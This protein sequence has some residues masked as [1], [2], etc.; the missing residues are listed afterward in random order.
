MVLQK[1]SVECFDDHLAKLKNAL[2]MMVDDEPI[3]TDVIQIHLETAGYRNFLITDRSGE[4][5]ELLRNQKPDVLLLDLKMP[6]VTGFDILSEMRR[7]QL[8]NN[9]PVIVLTSSTSPETKL[10]VLKLGASDFLS[11]P[12]DSSE[13]ILRLQNTLT[14]KAYQDQLAY[15]DS[16][17]GLP[18]RRLFIERLNQAVKSAACKGESI[19]L[20]HIGL[21][22]FKQI[23]DT[24]G[25]KIGDMLLGEAVVR[26]RDSLRGN[27]LVT[28]LVHARPWNDLARFGGD[29]FSVILPEYR[30]VDDLALVARG[31]LDSMRHIF[32]IDDH[33]IY[34]TPS[35]GIATFPE[36]A[37]NADT[38]IKQAASAT[39][40]AKQ[41]GRNNFQFYSEEINA[42]SAARMKMASRLRKALENDEFLLH[43][44]PQVDPGADRVSG[45]EAL[46]RWNSP[47]YGN[48]SPAEFTPLAEENG[49]I[50][51]IGTWVIQEACRQAQE[52]QS[53]GLTDITV[54]VNVSMEQFHKRDFKQ[55]VKNALDDS[56]LCPGH[57]VLEITESLMMENAER[58]IKTLHEL[59]E[60]GV[61][62]SIDDFG[63]GYSSLSYLTR[64][65]VDELKIASSFVTNIHEDPEHA[66]V[67]RAI[68]AMAKSLG[69]RVVA[70]GVEKEG[71]LRFLTEKRCDLIQG[72]YYSKPLAKEQLP[73]FVLSMK[74]HLANSL[75]NNTKEVPGLSG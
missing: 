53:R 59:K 14:A 3:N 72:Y 16:L 61:D 71:P 63:T 44:Q 5:M 56:G 70:E 8:L 37:D 46:L 27:E 54:S 49:M 48:V 32:I 1:E 58:H 60:L 6:D 51:P 13:L 23:N 25:P 64:F 33:D 20:L 57:L 67:G 30:Q 45:V 34:L 74:G 41:L 7:E 31:I 9:I 15:Y 66:A 68:I 65:P 11:K 62:L 4:A 52:W 35:I 69:L 73:E 47:V 18:N 12:V 38:L 17:T 28:R 36:D 22:R 39:H 26:I 2:I 29:E 43:Y 21:D 55:I 24:L 50:V 40:H 10:E 42:R 19:G 75:F